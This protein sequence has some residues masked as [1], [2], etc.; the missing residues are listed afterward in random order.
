M[1]ENG[2]NLWVK[3]CFFL[4]T[5]AVNQSWAPALS[6]LWPKSTT[7][8]LFTV[9]SLVEGSSLLMDQTSLSLL[10]PH[11]QLPP[12]MMLPCAV[13]RP[14][15]TPWAPR[16]SACS[17]CSRP[18]WP[19]SMACRRM[20][21]VWVKIWPPCMRRAMGGDAGQ[22]LSCAGSCVGPCRGPASGWRVRDT[23]WRGWRSWWR[24]P[25]RWS[26]SLGRW[27]RAPGWWSCCLN[28][29]DAKLIRRWEVWK[30]YD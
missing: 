16:W 25:S 23:G 1:K 14:E 19:G 8:T 2:L 5:S 27:W 29:L 21:V 20:S 13:W 18:F 26:A 6:T 22:G 28:S 15:W 10:H 30:Q 24:A 11:H 12:I 7:Q 9:R 3:S 4:R 17:T